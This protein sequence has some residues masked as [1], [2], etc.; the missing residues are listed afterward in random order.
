MCGYVISACVILVVL[1]FVDELAK[2][3]VVAKTA[4]S[5]SSSEELLSQIND[6]KSEIIQ[7]KA[8]K[9]DTESFKSSLQLELEK[10]GVYYV[11]IFYMLL[12]HVC[13]CLRVFLTYEDSRTDVIVE[14]NI[15]CTHT[16]LSVWKNAVYGHFL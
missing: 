12:F 11:L 4:V 6:L 8:S 16:N 13:S 9:S 1:L 10:K 3:N 7:I 5:Q 15:K 14:L 2:A